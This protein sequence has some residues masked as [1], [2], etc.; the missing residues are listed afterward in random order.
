MVAKKDLITKRMT[1]L[2]NKLADI[3]K[4]AETR[5]ELVR[6][7]VRIKVDQW[8]RELQSAGNV[9]YVVGREEAG[10]YRSCVELVMSRFLPS[11]FKVCTCICTYTIH[12]DMFMYVYIIWLALQYVW[13]N[14][15]VRSLKVEQ[16][17]ILLYRFLKLMKVGVSLV[18]V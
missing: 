16:L 17:S 12:N 14:T 9:R 13:Y 7:R 10:W 5:V 4:E 6:A 2:E 3:I 15:G 11:D 1:K 18:F 8:A